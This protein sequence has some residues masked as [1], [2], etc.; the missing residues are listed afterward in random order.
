MA[1]DKPNN[2]VAVQPNQTPIQEVPERHQ[3]GTLVQRYR[4]NKGMTI[5]ELSAAVDID[6]EVLEKVEAFEVPLS[7]QKLQDAA[8]ALGVRW[9]PLLEAS[10]S[11]HRAVWREQGNDGG[12]QL[13]EQ[14]SQVKSLREPLN[15]EA[16]HALIR[17]A[18]EMLFLH[19]VLRESSERALQNAM[20]TRKV[21]SDHGIIDKDAPLEMLEDPKVSCTNCGSELN[22][23]TMNII[24]YV[25]DGGGDKLYFCNQ[26]CASTWSE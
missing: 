1:E 20:Q 23:N 25:P 12:V 10:R 16:E 26:E 4:I 18:D 21:L 24:G 17:A 19:N 15:A 8:A 7:A 6:T 11:F 9:E 5:K 22:R 14:E 13:S 3:L 2:V